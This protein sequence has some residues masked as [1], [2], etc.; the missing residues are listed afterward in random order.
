MFV[1]YSF[2]QGLF[3]GFIKTVTETSVQ[4]GKEVWIEVINKIMDRPCMA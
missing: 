1:F 3:C 4:L 2:W